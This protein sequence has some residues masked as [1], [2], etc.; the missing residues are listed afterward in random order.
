MR[1]PSKR[2]SVPKPTALEPLVVWSSFNA[3]PAVFV[4]ALVSVVVML[5]V[6]DMERRSTGEPNAFGI[7]ENDSDVASFE[8]VSL[9][10][11]A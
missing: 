6:L 9:S 3:T 8:S 2:I 7:V 4:F 1:S 10:F 5:P 11:L